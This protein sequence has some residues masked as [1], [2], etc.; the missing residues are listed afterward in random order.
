MKELSYN[1]TYHFEGITFIFN[2]TN[3]MSSDPSCAASTDCI[4]GEGCNSDM[5][6]GK[7]IYLLGF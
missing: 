3:F 4:S 5:V 2:P 6:C 1:Q 7:C